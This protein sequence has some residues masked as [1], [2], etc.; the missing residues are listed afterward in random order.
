MKHTRDNNILRP[1][2]NLRTPIL[3]PHSKI[4]T[5]QR[6]SIEKLSRR[7]IILQILLRADIA[8]EDYLAYL[9]AVFL[10]IYQHAIWLFRLDDT[11]R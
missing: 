9:L 6:P 10:D 5:M 8:K 2:Q 4:T 7:F 11:D 1:I 3:M